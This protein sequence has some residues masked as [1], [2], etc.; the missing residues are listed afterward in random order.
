LTTCSAI[1]LSSSTSP[2]PLFLTTCRPS[3]LTSGSAPPPSTLEAR[4]AGAWALVVLLV[5]VIALL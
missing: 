2:L 4:Y 3:T 1:V 5:L